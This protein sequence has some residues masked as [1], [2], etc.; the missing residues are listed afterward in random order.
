MLVSTKNDLYY[1]IM[2][3]CKNEMYRVVMDKYEMT[4]IKGRKIYVDIFRIW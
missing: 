4:D 2:L 3:K 1:M